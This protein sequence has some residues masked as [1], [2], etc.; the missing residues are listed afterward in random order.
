MFG[1]K[2]HSM[3]ALAATFSSAQ[4]TTIVYDG[5][6]VGSPV[7]NRPI[8][9]DDSPPTEL[10]GLGTAV[11]YSYQFF[12]VDMAGDYSFQS[13]VTVPNNW[14]NYTFLYIGAFNSN[15]PFANILIGNDD[16]PQIGT[17]GFKYRLEANTQYTFVTTGFD[18]DDFGSFRN[19]IRRLPE[20]GSIAP[21]FGLALVG[22]A[23]AYRP[24]G[25]CDSQ[26]VTRSR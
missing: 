18:N 12:Q 2:T 21:I 16:N 14:D 4:A 22:M 20:S 24:C 9:D 11:S 15:I 13:T 19:I 6:T 5:T 17:S 7:W 25:S 3:F 1:A 23:L 10:S 8:A 26:K